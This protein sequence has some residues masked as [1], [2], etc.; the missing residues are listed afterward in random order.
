[1]ASVLSQSQNF[2]VVITTTM[3]LAE[4]AMA[5]LAYH[6]YHNMIIQRGHFIECH[7]LIVPYKGSHRA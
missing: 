2:C 3:T 7:F 1:M 5:T 4:E 6:G